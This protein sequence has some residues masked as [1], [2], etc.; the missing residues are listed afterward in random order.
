MYLHPEQGAIRE[1][2]IPP[3]DPAVAVADQAALTS[4]VAAG[5][6]PTKAEYDALRVDVAA[7]RTK[8]NALLASLRAADFLDT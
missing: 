8:I 3:M 2:I 1:G 6:T 5:A 7:G 4:V